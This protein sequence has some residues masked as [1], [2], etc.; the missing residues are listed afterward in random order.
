MRWAHLLLGVLLTVALVSGIAGAEI[1]ED[2]IYRINP[3]QDFSASFNVYIPADLDDSF[4]ELS[5]MLHPKLAEK[6]KSGT[7]KD[8]YQYHA[9]LGRWMRNNWALWKGSR[10]SEWFNRKGIHEPDDMSG[11]ILRSFWRHLNS[12][13][14]EFDKQVRFYEEYWK[15]AQEGEKRERERAKD[16]EQQIRKLMMG[17]SIERAQVSR[18]RMANRS[19]GGL[20]ARYLARFRSGV[21]MAIRKD[22]VE[23]FTTLTTPGYFLDLH[24]KQIHPIKVPEIEELQFAVV[25]GGVAYFSGSTKGKPTLVSVDSS[26]RSV[27]PLPVEDAFP[28]LGIDGARL[29]V[30]YKNSIY[31][32]EGE[33]WEAIY[34]G[35]IQLPRSGPPP[36]KS[37]NTVLFRDE[38][39]GENMKRL[40]WLELTPKAKLVPLDQDIGVVGP[41]GPRW[42]NSF[43]YCI[44]PAGDMWATLGEGYAKKSLVKRSAKGTYSLAI[45]HNSVQFDGA[46]L[47]T[48]GSDDG[49]SVSAVSMGKD[50]TV[51]AAGDR[52]LYAIQGKQIKQLL[53]F[54][55][56]KQ[57]IPIDDGKNVLH[58]GWDPSDILKL[59]DE[60]YII[61][62]A[63]GGIY[64][65]TRGDSGKYTMTALDET[66]GE[67]L[68]F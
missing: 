20:R 21:L 52:G 28:Q 23:D 38:G 41:S 62:G 68:T 15:K 46:L 4:K 9:G 63:F 43:S 64:I 66:L 11:I 1:D 56:T 42:E 51:L 65:I 47:G 18:I 57:E 37:R 60:N 17:L 13:P 25:A 32:L 33:A 12:Q 58:W 29:L 26:K 5:R 55:N 54:E 24:T 3:T 16:A 19:D 59:D 10:L 8:L 61:S 36:Q 2:E 35:G 50:G 31:A 45:T 22:F 44:T 39:R 30:A 27:L 6:I 40:W 7:E 48:E 67:E 49:L 34:R 53:V 14:I